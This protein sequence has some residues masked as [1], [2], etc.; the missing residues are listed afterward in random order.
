MLPRLIKALAAHGWRRTALFLLRLSL[1]AQ[2]RDLA[3]LQRQLRLAAQSGNP[4]RIAGACRALLAHHPADAQALEMLAVL[5][6]GRGNNQ[7]ARDVLAQAH[8]HGALEDLRFFNDALIDPERARTAGVY[9]ATLH[10]VEIE[11]AYWSILDGEKVYNTEAHNRALRNSPY[12][13]GRA[14]PGNDAYIYRLPGV[15]RHIEASC[16]HLGGDHNFCHWI[17]RNM[18]KLGVLE[19]TPYAALPL[20]VNADLRRHQEEF[21]ELLSIPEERLIR[22][23]RPARV[24]VRELV[25]PTNITNHAKMGI[26]TQWLRRQLAHCMDEAPAGDLLFVSRHDA[27]V[28]RLLNEDELFAALQPLGFESIL[29]GALPVREQI[30]RFSRAR[31]IVGAHGAAL[32]NMVFAPPGIHLI[33]LTTTF[34]A[35]IPDFHVLARICGLR[36]SSIVCDDYDFSR[37]EP[38][39]ADIDFRAD[40]A[41]VLAEL[42][43]RVPALFD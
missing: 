28:R 20:L 36:F 3:L 41:Q 32:G 8:R 26:G 30:R 27:R 7:V 17:T 14:S 15:S 43:R 9:V 19:G 10:D 40:V 37:P 24:Q 23:E 22:V 21:L 12:V 35:H 39:Q 29:P 38:Y 31:V 25:V 13:Q 33:E 4:G 16:V 6:L 5:E 1:L 18:V 11:T 34:K 42:R 2:P